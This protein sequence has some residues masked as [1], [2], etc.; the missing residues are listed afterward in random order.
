M[1]KSMFTG[2][3]ILQ[4][5][6]ATHSPVDQTHMLKKTALDLFFAFKIRAVSKQ[7]PNP[8]PEMSIS[9]GWLRSYGMDYMLSF[10][11]EGISSE[12][13]FI[14]F[15]SLHQIL[16]CVFIKREDFSCNH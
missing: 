1:Q 8:A 6:Q 16:S 9:R 10:E 2:L 14:F 15:E 11:R 5:S 12:S 3:H 13:V 4:A 7:E